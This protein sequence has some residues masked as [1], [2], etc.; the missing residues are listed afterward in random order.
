MKHL[1][2][3]QFVEW[4]SG[5]RNDEAAQHLREC[6]RCMDEVRRLSL[7]LEGFKAEINAGAS[8]RYVPFTGA[9]IR[10]LAATE[11]KQKRSLWR[12]LPAPALAALAVLAV[13]LS[14]PDPVQA[15]LPNTDAADDA[16]L[17]AVNSDV[18]RTAPAALRPAAEL[19]KERNQILTGSQQKKK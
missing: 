8:G 3:E 12:L 16:L 7:A 6:A 15:P 19:N 5:E 18:Y 9:H 4:A 14:R 17:L 11:A 2:E 1:H 10:A 13:V